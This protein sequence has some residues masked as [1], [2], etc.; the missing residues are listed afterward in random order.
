MDAEGRNIWKLVESETTVILVS[1]EMLSTSGFG[2]L[3]NCKIFQA[4]LF[5]ITVDEVH[6]LWTWGEEFRPAFCQIGFI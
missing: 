6:L 4:R 1:P 2:S 5:A 3:I